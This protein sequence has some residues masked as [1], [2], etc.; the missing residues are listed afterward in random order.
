MDSCT[1][2]RV[3]SVAVSDSVLPGCQADLLAKQAASPMA[4]A[5]RVTGSS[6]I[7]TLSAAA[8]QSGRSI[9]LLGGAPGTAQKTAAVLV[10]HYPN[11]RIAGIFSEHLELGSERCDW[12]RISAALTSAK[13]DIV[14]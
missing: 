11:L 3:T 8:A 1:G 2:I 5:E 14:Y 12:D 4:G 7:W 6:L 9:Y 13:P 10:S